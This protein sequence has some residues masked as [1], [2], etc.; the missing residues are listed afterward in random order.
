LR[1]SL[2]SLPSCPS[3]LL[4]Y[5]TFS[6]LTRVAMSGINPLLFLL[7]LQLPPS[8]LPVLAHALL[9]ILSLALVGFHTSAALS[10]L[11]RNSLPLF[12][13]GF[14]RFSSLEISTLIRLLNCG[15]HLFSLF[16]NLILVQANAS[17]Q[18][19]LELPI[20]PSQ[21]NENALT[22]FLHSASLLLILKPT[23]HSMHMK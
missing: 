8:C 22:H 14:L 7:L 18:L 1:N 9:A 11:S 12:S 15:S 19:V 2:P 3:P 5:R 6:K 13:I 21:S 20:L 16:G 17:F 4:L 23:W 10:Y